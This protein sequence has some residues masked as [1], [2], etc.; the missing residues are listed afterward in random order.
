MEHAL[1]R[2]P[3]RLSGTQ[4][5]D[6]EQGSRPAVGRTTLA[7]ALPPAPA[8]FDTPVAWESIYIPNATAA[9]PR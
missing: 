4:D 8:L 2:T 9:I 7:A 1:E 3:G 5:L 6:D